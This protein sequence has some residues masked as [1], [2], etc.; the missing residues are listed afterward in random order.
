MNNKER[1]KILRKESNRLS[2][3][4]GL[5]VWCGCQASLDCNIV[6]D[7]NPYSVNLKT[8]HYFGY[9]LMDGKYKGVCLKEWLKE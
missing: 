6:M 2:K 4:L 7:I 1:V 8:G 9:D 5:Q 3:K